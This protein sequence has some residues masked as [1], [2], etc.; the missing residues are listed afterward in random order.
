[1]KL[2]ALQTIQ[3]HLG[4]HLCG[5]GKLAVGPVD[6]PQCLKSYVNGNKIQGAPV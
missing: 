1:M 4:F 3:G 6:P 5:Y 2:G